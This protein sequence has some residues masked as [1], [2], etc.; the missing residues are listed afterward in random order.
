MIYCKLN[1]IGKYKKIGGNLEIAIEY[2]INNNL[3]DIEDKQFNIKE[4]DVFAFQAVNKLNDSN[5]IFLEGHKSHIDIQIILQGAE[6]FYL[7]DVDSAV[8]IDEYNQTTD[9]QKYKSNNLN[10]LVVSE[11]EVLIVFP[12]DL[13]GPGYIADIEKTHARKIVFKVRT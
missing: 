11:G 9:Y 2:I 1:D 6:K 12:E 3:Y 13:H 8:K 10:E 4:N 5:E 7:S